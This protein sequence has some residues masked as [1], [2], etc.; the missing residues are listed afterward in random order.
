MKESM[1]QKEQ[2]L[3]NPFEE[4]LKTK[5][6]RLCTVS[7]ICDVDQ[8]LI[9]FFKGIGHYLPKDRI[10]IEQEYK[11]GRYYVV[12]FLNWNNEKGESD[13]EEIENRCHIK[14]FV[15]RIELKKIIRKG[16]EIQ[17]KLNKE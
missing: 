1:D 8:F 7:T 6:F 3:Q 5:H 15:K 12:G 2:L 17:K 16:K 14:S 13:Y 10:G 11:K 9:D 4:I